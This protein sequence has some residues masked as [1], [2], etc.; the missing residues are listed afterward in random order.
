MFF[1]KK[2]KTIPVLEGCENMGK[3]FY[4]IVIVCV[5]CILLNGCGTTTVKDKHKTG[6]EVRSNSVT[7]TLYNNLPDEIVDIL[8]NNEKFIDVKS[9]KSATVNTLELKDTNE[10]IVFGKQY[11]KSYI[12]C[13]LDD[14]KEQEL[15]VKMEKPSED[16]YLDCI[17]IF[18]K[19]DKN[20]YAYLYSN[21]DICHVYQNGILEGTSGAA[22][23]MYYKVAFNREKRSE[24][25]VA[26]SIGDI[27]RCTY[28]INKKNVSEEKFYR[29]ISK[30]SD[31]KSIKWSDL[32]GF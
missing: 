32:S 29:Y 19:Q 31:E 16:S 10:E 1:R 22:D 14:D 15:I 26:Q 8:S 6:K 17:Y 23:V 11:W 12:I 5:T 2:M 30:F 28:K 7:E 3:S 25:I 9:K 4:R 18:D 24:D 13:D 21:R 27:T 20:V